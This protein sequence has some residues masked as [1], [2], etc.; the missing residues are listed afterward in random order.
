MSFTC[1]LHAS[2]SIERYGKI[3]EEVFFDHVMAGY[4]NYEELRWP[5]DGFAA[6]LKKIYVFSTIQDRSTSVFDP[7]CNDSF[8][9]EAHTL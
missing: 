8:F 3:I 4:R 1:R 7:T 2:R 6:E 5:E 9:S